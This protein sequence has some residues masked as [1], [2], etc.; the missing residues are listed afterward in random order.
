[1][2]ATGLYLLQCLQGC[3]G[4]VRLPC[5]FPWPACGLRR[6]HACH[7]RSSAQC[8][9]LARVCSCVRQLRSFSATVGRCRIRLDCCGQVKHAVKFSNK[10]K[11]RDR[12]D[13][14]W[15]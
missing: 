13:G 2:A 6:R 5:S 14:R 12:S 11:L 15:P 3:K 1:M 10:R 4:C 9:I 8:M 7:H